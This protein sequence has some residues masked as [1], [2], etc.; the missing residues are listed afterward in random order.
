MQIGTIKVNGQTLRNNASWS[1]GTFNFDYL[2][3]V[4]WDAGGVS[5]LTMTTWI[6]DVYVDNSFSRVMLCKKNTFADSGGC[7]M[8]LATSWS[9]GEITATVNQGSF[10]NGDDAYIYVVNADG[11]V[12]SIGHRVTISQEYQPLS[13][14]LS[15]AGSLIKLA[16]PGP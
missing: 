8:Q 12:N 16:E 15:L 10:V 9:A 3:L 7:E 13:R 5:P 4:G 6:D 14:R 11:E 2:W 1:A